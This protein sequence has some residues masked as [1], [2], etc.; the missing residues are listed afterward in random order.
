MT[1]VEENI[2]AIP[3]RGEGAPPWLD[4]IVAGVRPPYLQVALVLLAYGP[5]LAAH[6]RRLW[7]TEYYR[8]FPLLLVAVVGLAWSRQRSHAQRYPRTAAV[9]SGVAWLLLAVSI[10]AWSPWGAMVSA[11]IMLAAVL[12]NSRRAG[13][14][15]TSVW[16]LLWFLVPLPFRWD[17]NLVLS[18]Q[19]IS[20]KAGSYLLEFME[21]DHLLTSHVIEVPGQRFLVEEACSGIRTL[22]VLV[23]FTAVFVIWTLRPVLHSLLLLVSAA[24]WAT[25]GNSL[26]V[27]S[28]VMI[29]IG[30]GVNV[31]SGWRHE[32]LGLTV[33]LFTGIMLACTDRL[34]MFF[35]EPIAV[36][37]Q[38]N[39]ESPSPNLAEPVGDT[40]QRGTRRSRSPVIPLW[41]GV[42]F[43]LLA[44]VQLGFVAL[45]GR[46]PSDPADYA[47]TLAK[48][49]TET[50]LRPEYAGWRRGKYEAISRDRDSIFGNYSH[51]W[52]YERP[53]IQAMVSIDF[54]FV[55]WHELLNC[56][57][58]LGWE[59]ISWRVVHDTDESMDGSI[60]F[61]EARLRHPRGDTAILLFSEVDEFG[62]PL[63]PPSNTKW[64]LDSFWVAVRRRIDKALSGL[65]MERTTCQFQILA[66]CRSEFTAD[67]EQQVEELFQVTRQE[68]VSCFLDTVRAERRR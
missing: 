66:N 59:T 42:L 13:A 7:L 10:I 50:S 18:L 57:E 31:A 5:L 1:Q 30:L 58:G 2:S 35:L 52:S 46:T 40:K 49:L 28:I 9:L 25:A 21:F 3:T 15:L 33:F 51:I 12:L 45:G 64:S 16:L 38:D 48:E 68:L 20:S 29:Q 27:A 8:F 11:N 23:A 47:E 34:L 26:R 14:S 67:N 65:G 24:L 61:V 37:R 63:L 19:R 44:S 22:F 54:P 55:G 53:A 60:P 39:D 62:T 36:P 6:F 43:G 41:T 56:Y 17:E 32:L 4:R